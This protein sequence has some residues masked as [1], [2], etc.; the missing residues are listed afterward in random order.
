MPYQL[1][2]FADGMQECVF[3]DI[4]HWKERRHQT[5]QFTAQ[6]TP[7]AAQEI[8]LQSRM[9]LHKNDSAPQASA[10]S[11]LHIAAQEIEPI[12]RILVMWLPSNEN[13]NGGH[14]TQIRVNFEHICSPWRDPQSVMDRTLSIDAFINFFACYGSR[15]GIRDQLEEFTPTD[16]MSDTYPYF[17]R[18]ICFGAVKPW[19]TESWQLARHKTWALLEGMDFGTFRLTIRGER[20]DRA[21]DQWYSIW[22]NTTDDVVRF[23][24]QCDHSVEILY[25]RNLAAILKH[26]EVAPDAGLAL[27]LSDIVKQGQW[28]S[29]LNVEQWPEEGMPD[30][31]TCDEQ[32]PSFNSS[33]LEMDAFAPDDLFNPTRFSTNG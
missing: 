1:I 6:T 31:F 14:V 18:G 23:R 15:S 12:D 13:D 29:E 17:L 9:D 4:R 5:N 22:V 25:A 7:Q 10:F 32:S 26:L 11:Q 30:D 27:N 21:D 2:R 20:S 19:I 3:H 24:F 8:Y 16:A 28:L 33:L